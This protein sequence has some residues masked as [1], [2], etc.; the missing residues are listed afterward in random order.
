MTD[1]SKPDRQ[2]G[3]GLQDCQT[4]YGT[5]RYMGRF[6]HN[7]PDCPNCR[8]SGKVQREPDEMEMA[9]ELERRLKAPQPTPDA[10]EGAGD[11]FYFEPS[12]DGMGACI[13]HAN[14][15]IICEAKYDDFG[16]DPSEPER[17]MKRLVEASRIN[18]ATP[19]DD[20]RAKIYEILQKEVTANKNGFV[21]Y[22][23]AVIEIATLVAAPPKPAP[24]AM[25]EAWSALAR[26]RSMTPPEF[27]A[28]HSCVDLFETALRALSAPAPSPDRQISTLHKFVASQQDIDPEVRDQICGMIAGLSVAV[29]SP[30]VAG[31]HGSRLWN[32][33]KAVALHR[34]LA[35]QVCHV[36]TAL[37]HE[38]VDALVLSPSIGEPAPVR[39][40][41]QSSS[42]ESK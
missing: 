40:A 5:G 19:P 42:E 35:K 34:P 14:G 29:P 1:Q 4:C 39:Q 38:L 22:N 24:D 26:L 18:A 2:D 10:A 20:L 13:H 33:A 17:I 36:P 31:E 6:G 11:N 28:Y 9:A 23:K 3:D 8:G 25:R 16:N 27:K 37:M 21:I 12:G 7:D 41:P 30:D 15:A 32:A